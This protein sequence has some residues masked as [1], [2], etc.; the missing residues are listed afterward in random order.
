MAESEQSDGHHLRA[1][2]GWLELGLPAEASGELQQ[3]SPAGQQQPVGLMLRWRV[4]AEF[5]QWNEAA[6]VGDELVQQEPANPFGWVHR[7]Y[8]L[9]EL[10]RTQEAWDQLRPVLEKFETEELI[11]YNLACYACQLGRLEEAKDLLNTAAKRGEAKEI[12]ARAAIDDDLAPIRDFIQ[13]RR[14]R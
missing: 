11:A 9:H 7:S 13:S 3:V 8:A 5:K 4:H 10:K 12:W 6:R 14:R 2:E 1:A